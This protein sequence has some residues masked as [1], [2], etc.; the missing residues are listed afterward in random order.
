MRCD[1]DFVGSSYGRAMPELAFLGVTLGLAHA[2]AE[3]LVC[4]FWGVSLRLLDWLIV[5]AL[6]VLVGVACGVGIWFASRILRQ[7]AR[8]RTAWDTG[9]GRR[10]LFWA[11]AVT[12][13]TTVAWMIVL[14]RGSG[15]DRWVAVLWGGVPALALLLLGYRRVGSF[16]CL[17]LG[18]LALAVS[19][20]AA[21]SLPQMW[22]DLFDA[23]T[24]LPATVALWC[25]P[26]VLILAI[27]LWRGP[28]TP[29]AGSRRGAATWLAGLA[30]VSVALNQTV[31]PL[32][33][34]W[35]VRRGSSAVPSGNGD[36]PN[37]LLVVLD[38]VR[39]D[40]LDCFGYAR[41][42]MPGLSR[43]ADE[44]CRVAMPIWATAPATLSAHASMFTGHYPHTHE[45]HLPFLDHEGP[46][47]EY[48]Y[49]LR[50]DLPTLAERLAD[51]GF[52]TV[53]IAANYAILSAYGLSRGFDTYD[54]VPGAA[55]RGEQL[56]WLHAAPL[57]G[58]S[59]GEFVRRSLPEA[60]AVRSNLFNRWAPPYRQAG[61]ITDLALGWL[62]KRERRP[63]FLFLNYFDAHDPYVSVPGLRDRFVPEDSSVDWAG[64][65]PWSLYENVLRREAAVPP[66]WLEHLVALYDAELLYLDQQVERLL[67]GLR[68]LG[69]FDDTLIVITSD[70]GEAFMEHGVLQHAT[71]IYDTQI[72]VPLFI[73][74]PKST[75]GGPTA[76]PVWFQ[77]VD[78]YPSVMDL[79]GEPTPDGIAGSAWAVGREHGLAEVFV[80]KPDVAWL[81]R[82][83]CAVVLGSYKYIQSTGGEAELYDLSGDPG[84]RS[85]LI[86]TRPGIEARARRIIERRNAALVREVWSGEEDGA[87]Q[88]KLR[89]LGYVD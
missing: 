82:E 68:R 41:R 49:S 88:D 57:G 1:T 28:K 23:R 22:P 71:S 27:A 55:Y 4:A 78:L 74:F 86:G 30:I 70:H 29:G 56:S 19:N 80:Y 61:E 63:F 62:S 76:L 52:E 44:S 6:C 13:H 84:E 48:G 53:G 17:V 34:G 8:F 33:L 64:Y 42:T 79:I 24:A 16:A 11:V 83:L 72:R 7:T 37:I 20:V 75:P 59:F 12:G 77:F 67:A 9:L 46:R 2:V 40:H 39:A 66:G 73:K 3:S 36:Y 50:R 21:T 18:S 87:L 15:M 60:I 26:A 38:T 47:P 43:F 54:C 14:D 45:A 51:L 5:G 35:H 81:R 65:V 25:L 89:S 85:N 31:F 32:R 58:G 69:C 10:R